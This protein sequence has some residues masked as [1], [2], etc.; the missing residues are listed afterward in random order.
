MGVITPFIPRADNDGW[1]AA[2]RD[3]L[4]ELADRLQAA[5]GRVH[6]T[7]GVSDKGEPWCVITD[8]D[9]EVIV[10]VAR[11]DG[12]FVVHHAGED[13]LRVGDTL[14]SACER[15][16]GEDWAAGRED[17]V[18]SL[19]RRQAQSVLAI[20]VLADFVYEV[21]SADAA[22]P[23]GSVTFKADVAA[24]AILTLALAASAASAAPED[25]AEPAPEPD[26]GQVLVAAQGEDAPPSSARLDGGDRL[27]P[28]D[29]DTRDSAPGDQPAP[30]P[31]PQPSDA[32]ATTQVGGDGNDLLRG[33]DGA[34]VLIG[35]AGDDTAIGGGADDQLIGGEDN[36]VLLGQGGNDVAYGNGG[37]DTVDG[38]DGDDWVR[39][40]QDQDSVAGGAG[41]DVV[42]GDKGDDTVSGGDG[43]DTFLFFAGGGLDQVTDFNRAQGDTLVIEDHATY[44]VTQQGDDTV[45]EVGATDRVVLVNVQVTSLTEGW[46]VN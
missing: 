17:V 5:F 34:D 40:G 45:V 14:W 35:G 13:T 15:L 21:E 44:Q 39:G 31:E 12:Q 6:A 28:T 7:Y 29:A 16:M 20:A 10:H 38:G 46:I 9:D 24:G 4:A 8:D 1:T 27:Q 30:P 19:S 3:R 26:H 25:H 41:Q 23:A 42:S 33:G 32:R 11:I 2:E 22:A 18:V 43:A 37:D 36:D